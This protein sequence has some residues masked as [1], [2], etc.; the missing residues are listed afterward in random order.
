MPFELVPK[1]H[2]AK[3]PFGNCVSYIR[4]ASK[5]MKD[6]DTQYRL[7]QNTITAC[8]VDVWIP[9]S[10]DPLH[11]EKLW[12]VYVDRIISNGREAGKFLEGIKT[13]GKTEKAFFLTPQQE[14]KVAGDVFEML[15]RSV[16]W[17]NCIEESLKDPSRQYAALTLGDN[18]DLKMLFTP[19]AAEKLTKYESEL[20]KKNTLLCYSTP[21]V[22]AL[23]ISSLSSEIRAYF[24]Q[25]IT[26]LGLANQAILSGAKSK[27]ENKVAP[28]NIIFAAGVKTSIRSDRMYQFLFE[29]NAWKFIWRSI[30][31]VK[32]SKYYTLMVGTY[33]ADPA[34]LAA[35]DFSSVMGGTAN[36][37]RAIDGFIT[38]DTPAKLSMWFKSALTGAERII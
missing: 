9:G 35:L 29:A 27:L 24:S 5:R 30:F 13:F 32:P 38:G 37:E 19:E 33:G 22:I 36:A 8:A 6:R 7:S 11:A 31:K 23:D 4:E 21:D 34:K 18:Y 12:R 20:K 26:N 16:L 2:C 15:I 3:C 10:N 1:K 28:E 14:A 17:N 25:P